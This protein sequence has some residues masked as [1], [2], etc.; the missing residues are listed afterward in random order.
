MRIH[1]IIFIIQLKFKIFENNSYNKII[2]KKL[3]LIKNENVESNFELARET[4][5]YEIEQLL[6]KKISCEKSKYLVK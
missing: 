2:N 6:N 1:S 3:L 4:S 5:L